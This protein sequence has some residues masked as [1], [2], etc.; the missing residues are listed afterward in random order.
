MAMNQ[1]EYLR[2]IYDDRDGL[3][4]LKEGDF[5]A[6]NSAD[7]ADGAAALNGFTT[8]GNRASQVFLGNSLAAKIPALGV[9]ISYWGE[10]ARGQQQL[11]RMAHWFA[12]GNIR[13]L[14]YDP[15]YR[16]AIRRAENAGYEGAKTA[17][18]GFGGGIL[19][20][21]AAGSLAALTPLAAFPPALAVVGIVGAIAGGSAA[22]SAHDAAFKQEV[23]DPI[24]IAMQVAKA[25]ELD[26]A[27]DPV[28]VF[29]ALAANLKGEQATHVD[30]ILERYTGTKYFT[31]AMAD[32][33][34]IPKIE[35]MMNNPIIDSYIRAQTGMT[36]DYAIPN[37]P[38][39]VQYAELINSG[40]MQANKILE[41]GSGMYAQM[42]QDMMRQ[43]GS[44]D[45]QML[46]PNVPNMAHS[47]QH[48]IAG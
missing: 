38:V 12:D 39:A 23:Q 45:T 1:E 26:G 14:E 4:K 37:K 30:R 27:V 29:A 32:P 20:G 19:G 21:A 46:T 3:A 36:I 42:Q 33:D 2:R 28:M 6:L 24:T 40:Q 16:D 13:Q 35:A 9:G 48:N 44:M 34:N 31:Q 10:G 25:K 41:V 15:N 7:A 43:G 18:W 22:V 5:R 47:N 11:D 17:A 8:W